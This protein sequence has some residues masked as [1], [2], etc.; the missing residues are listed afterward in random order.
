MMILNLFGFVI[1]YV[2]RFDSLFI[3]I[4]LYGLIDYL[5]FFM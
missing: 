5:V 2:I 4:I 1:L 3:E